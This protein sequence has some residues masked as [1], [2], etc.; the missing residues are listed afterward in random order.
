MLSKQHTGLISIVVPVYNEALGI[1]KFNDSL[2]EVL[3]KNEINNYEVIYCDDGSRDHTAE[4]IRSLNAK[5]LNIKLIKL[6]RNFGK[7]SALT[8]GIEQAKGEAVI[9]LDG[10]SQHPVELIPEFISAWQEGAK[11][12]VGIRKS[13][14][15]AGF[16]KNLGSKI[17]HFSFN[18][19]TSQ[20]LESGSTD[21]RLI[22]KTVRAEFLKLKESDRITRGLIDWL[23]FD[24]S[25]IRFNANPRITGVA[26][27]SNRQLF[28]LAANTFVSLSPK[29]LYIFGFVGVGITTLSFG[30]GLAVFFEQVLIGDPMHWKFSGTA[31]L[32]MLVLFLIGIVLMSQGI[33]S[34]YV[35][36]IQSQSKGRPLF[37]ID[38]EKSAG[39][40]KDY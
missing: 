34:L 22:D 36:N 15:S 32:S 27:Y 10:D 12:V 39:I 26:Q 3:Q 5:N 18:K 28:K 38:H 8:A 13:N 23:G 1:A 31:M 25:Y 2:I 9:T 7:E 33:L 30:L 14:D 19:M 6:S 17:F 37:I 35:S 20:K 16:I 21:Y 11:V 40:H 4:I 29:P 24:R